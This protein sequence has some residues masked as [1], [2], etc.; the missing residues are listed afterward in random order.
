MWNS[1]IDRGDLY[2]KALEETWWMVSFGLTISVLIGLPLGILLVV[3]RPQHIYENRF[4]Y[5]VLNFIINIL[6]SIPFIILM[7]AMFPITAVIVGT[8]IGVKG[9]IPPLVFYTAPYIAR[10]IESALLEVDRG[11]I[12]AFQAM[13]AS[14]QQ[15]IT[16][17][18]LKEARPSITL[19]ITIATIGLIGATAIAGVIGAG[20]LGDLAL[21]YGFHRYQSDVMIWTVIILIIIVQSIQSLGNFIAKRLRKN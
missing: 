4:I 17:V 3:T 15:I 12:E 18:L 16:K 8:K 21:R 11:L 13:G 10:L 2:L 19:A 1:L 7:V 5:T 6:R 20:G 9:A 14:R